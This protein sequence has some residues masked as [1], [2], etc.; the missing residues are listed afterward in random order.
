MFQLIPSTTLPHKEFELETV[1][2][3]LREFTCASVFLSGVEGYE[4]GLSQSWFDSAHHDTPNKS[5]SKQSLRK[6][7]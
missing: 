7:V 2:K 3:L 6:M 4:G 1:L 5:I